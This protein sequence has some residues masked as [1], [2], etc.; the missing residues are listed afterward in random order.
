MT[1]DSGERPVAI[2]TGAARGIGLAVTAALVDSGYRVLATDLDRPEAEFPEDAVGWVFGDITEEKVLEQLVA[3]AGDQLGRVDALVNNAGITMPARITE[4]DAAALR[5]ML[6]TNLEAPYLLISKVLPLMVASGGGSIVNVASINAF[7]G[8]GRMST[9]SLAK[10]GLLALTRS[11]AIEHAVDGIRCNAVAPGPTETRL[12][13]SIT[14]EERERRA[15]RI[16]LRRAGE[17]DEIVPLIM[18]LLSP[19]ASYITGETVAA[20]GGYLALGTS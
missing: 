20:D 9:Y 7:V 16:P 11:V 12:Q 2:V 6:S 18:F 19:A 1:P 8:V 3:L 4:V 17:V 14:A 10:A 5:R 15:A 13:Q